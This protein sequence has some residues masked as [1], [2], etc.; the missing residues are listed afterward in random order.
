MYSAEVDTSGC[1]KIMKTDIGTSRHATMAGLSTLGLALKYGIDIGRVIDSD[2][3]AVG[4]VMINN[5][6]EPFEVKTGAR[7]AQLLLERVSVQ[8]SSRSRRW[9]KLSAA[10]KALAP[11]ERA[12]SRRPAERMWEPD[13][14]MLPLAECAPPAACAPPAE[15]AALAEC[16][17]P[18]APAVPPK[19]PRLHTPERRVP[20]VPYNRPVVFPRRP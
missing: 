20:P 19:R 4:I 14:T 5:G 12:H 17:S 13:C 6:M 9:K 18:A 3:R 2:Y 10:S 15:C 7:V 16:A 1:R 11:R 8:T